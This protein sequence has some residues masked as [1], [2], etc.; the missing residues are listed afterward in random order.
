M[1]GGRSKQSAWVS[2]PIRGVG[3]GGEGTCLFFGWVCAARDSKLVTRS[4]K[5]SLKIDTS[6]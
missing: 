6:F 2:V 3:G 5:I 1:K 4:D